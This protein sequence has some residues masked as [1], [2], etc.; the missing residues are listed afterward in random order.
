MYGPIRAF[1]SMMVPEPIATGPMILALL[2]SEIESPSRTGPRIWAPFIERL[3]L[4]FVTDICWSIQ[5][6]AIRSE[7]GLPTSVQF[8]RA[9]HPFRLSPRSISLGK[10]SFAKSNFVSGGMWSKIAGSQTYIPVE[11]RLEK[12][13][14][15]AGFSLKRSRS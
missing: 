5:R 15:G 11:A 4:M 6:S 8:P 14:P 2:P 12:I 1:S 9:S 10:R 3:P 13:S 7:E